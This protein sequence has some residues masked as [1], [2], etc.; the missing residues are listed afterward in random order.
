VVVDSEILKRGTSTDSH[1]LDY[2]Q[3]LELQLGAKFVVG[4]LTSVLIEASLIGKNFLAIVHNERGNLTSPDIVYR[5]YEHF[6]GIAKLPN[7]FFSESKTK[8]RQNFRFVHDQPQI[9][10]KEIDRFLSYF[11]HIS[12]ETYSDALLG[13]VDKILGEVE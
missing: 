4:G 1:P 8:L 13:A 2:A 3:L 5:S 11:Y 7:L 9:D 10:Q 12:A 6:D